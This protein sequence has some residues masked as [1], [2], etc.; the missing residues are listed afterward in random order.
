MSIPACHVGD[1][2]S[3]PRRGGDLLD[4][5]GGSDSKASV[6]N[7]GDLGS[8]PGSGRSPGEGNGNSFQYYS[9]ENPKDRG[10]WWAIVHEITK[11]QTPERSRAHTHTYQKVANIL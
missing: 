8:I 4:F 6:Y 3:I 10:A 1:R 7:A 9:L 11:S 5:P 2:G